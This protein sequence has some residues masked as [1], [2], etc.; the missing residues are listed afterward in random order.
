[1]AQQQLARAFTAA[2]MSPQ[3]FEQ[4]GKALETQGEEMVKK[5]KVRCCV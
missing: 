1:M 2:K 4:L 5:F 3:L